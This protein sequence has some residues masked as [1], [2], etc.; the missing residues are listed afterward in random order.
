MTFYIT[1]SYANSG[2]RFLTSS[3]GNKSPSL[4]KSNKSNKARRSIV[5]FIPL[6]T[7]FSR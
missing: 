4:S 1:T 6:F 2:L 5:K 7:R 3:K